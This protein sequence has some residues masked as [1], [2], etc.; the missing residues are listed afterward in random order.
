MLIFLCIFA[1]KK[2]AGVTHDGPFA[3][4]DAGKV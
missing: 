1:G 2:P 4:D 3:V